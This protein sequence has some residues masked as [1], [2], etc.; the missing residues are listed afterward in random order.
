MGSIWIAFEAFG[1]SI[2]GTRVAVWFLDADGRVDVD[3]CKSYCD[4]FDLNYNDGPYVVT[5]KKRPDLLGDNDEIVVLKLSG[6]SAERIPAVLNV[7]ERDLRASGE[8]GRGR[9]LYEEVKHRILTAAERYPD[10]LKGVLAVINLVKAG[11]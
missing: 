2:G 6:I 7:L 10:P 4:R 9:L 5:T 1:R 11:P 3:R 8:I